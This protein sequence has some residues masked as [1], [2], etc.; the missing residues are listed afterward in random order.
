MGAIVRPV[1]KE[2]A[3]LNINAI[4][5][6]RINVFKDFPYIYD[7]S[8]QYEVK[9]L[10]RYFNAPNAHFILAFDE[11][12]SSEMVGVATC[13]PLAE[14]DDFVKKPFI[15]MGYKIDEIFYFGESVL[16]PSY[17]G[18]GLGHKFFDAR[19]K[20]ALE[21]SK[22]NTTTFCAVVREDKH[23]LKPTDY[24]PLDT[25]WKKRGYEAVEN[26]TSQFEWLDVGEKKET[27]KTMQYWIKTWNR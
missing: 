23:H 25:F 7:G 24:K 19:E 26:L 11:T 4:A 21:F 16:L 10:E 14:E 3:K 6:L 5:R 15:E 8:L 1:T 9:Y 20:I 22:I 17:R 18:Q 27:T 12:M 2:F 13:L